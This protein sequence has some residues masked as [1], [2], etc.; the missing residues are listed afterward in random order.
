MNKWMNGRMNECINERMNECMNEWMN[1]CMN[2]C[3]YKHLIHLIYKYIFGFG[4]KWNE[5]N[6]EH[7]D[8]QWP[9]KIIIGWFQLSRNKQTRKCDRG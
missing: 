6:L 7:Q 9:T 8:I 4:R 3:V 1:E 2:E 5:V